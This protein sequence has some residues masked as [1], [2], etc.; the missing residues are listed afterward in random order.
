VKVAILSILLLF[1]IGTALVG[2]VEVSRGEPGASV[3]AAG[4]GVLF[5]LAAIVSAV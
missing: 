2:L 1:T 3:L 4:A 5:A